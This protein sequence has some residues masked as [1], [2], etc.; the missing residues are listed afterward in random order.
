MLGFSAANTEVD[1]ERKSEREYRNFMRMMGAIV[2][3]WAMMP[4]S[5]FS[6]QR[7]LHRKTDKCN[8][9]QWILR[10]VCWCFL[11]RRCRRA[12]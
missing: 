12:L 6:E 11:L 7:G 4:R 8:F 1:N 10:K 5:E 3:G 9:M 2:T